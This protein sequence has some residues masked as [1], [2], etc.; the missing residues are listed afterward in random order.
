[1]KKKLTHSEVGALVEQLAKE[2]QIA[3]ESGAGNTCYPI[4][5][6]GVSVAYLLMHA[7]PHL[8][9]TDRPEK[10]DF[11]VDD[12]IDSGET[13]HRFHDKYQKPFHALIDKR[14]TASME[15]VWIEFPWETELEQ[16]METTIVRLLQQI[17]EN[18]DRGGLKET[19]ERVARA[20][21]HW[22]SG[23]GT[24]P[25]DV[26]KEFEDGGEDYDNMVVVK[27]IP[28]YSHCEHHMA[29]FFGTAT[30]GYIPDG[31]IVGLSKLSRLLDV[32]A[33]RLQVQERLTRQVAHALYDVLRPK[34]VGVRIT[35][36]HLC[37]ESRGVK[38]QGHETV[39]T[40]LI[41]VFRDA[42]VRAEFLADC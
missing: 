17:G 12:L 5:R 18:P 4:P 25:K 39:T 15:G 27:D 8:A 40:E 22:T 9:I 13:Y 42:A 26:L 36:R 30:I 33:H 21:Q 23:Y 32:F 10:A 16:D 6:G 34:G 19:P 35:A 1:M 29:P 20:W 37:M 38:K 7:W 3:W 24:D 31:R 41:G 14:H 2:L 28:F 11:F